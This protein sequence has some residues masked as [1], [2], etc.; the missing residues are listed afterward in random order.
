MM[1]S[2]ATTTARPQATVRK[3]SARA[4][5]G[6]G[7]PATRCRTAQ[8][9]GRLYRIAALLL[10]AVATAA[11]P[12]QAQAPAHCRSEP[13]EIWCTTMTVAEDDVWYGWIDGSIGSLEPPNIFTYQ[14]GIQSR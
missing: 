9:T 3:G 8:G 2:L 12:V 6:A 7:A 1:R 14:G 4:P 5:R 11:L 13:R 10:I